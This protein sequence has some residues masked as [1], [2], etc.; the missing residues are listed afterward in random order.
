MREVDADAE[1]KAEIAEEKGVEELK[2]NVE[3]EEEEEAKV[4]GADAKVEV[5]CR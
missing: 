5:K 4:G 2:V 3:V 1:V